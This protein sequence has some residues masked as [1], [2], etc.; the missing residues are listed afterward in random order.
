MSTL[1]LIV[2]GI[3]TPEDAVKA[4]ECGVDAVWIS[5]HGGRQIDTV[6]TTVIIF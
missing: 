5:N 1:P 2:K 3:Q 4:V 6:P